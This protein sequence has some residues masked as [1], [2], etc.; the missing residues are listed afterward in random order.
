MPMT[1]RNNDSTRPAA[2]TAVYRAV[3]RGADI[4]TIS[5]TADGGEVMLRLAHPWQL[6]ATTIWERLKNEGIRNLGDVALKT[7]LKIP[8]N[9]LFT[10]L[11][12]ELAACGVILRKQ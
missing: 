8:T 9:R 3:Y 2:A 1:T 4:G 11:W 6:E 12:R 10:E 5:V 7:P